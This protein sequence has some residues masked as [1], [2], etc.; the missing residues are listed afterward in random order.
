MEISGRIFDVML[1]RDIN[2]LRKSLRSHSVDQ[3]LAMI[4]AANR[5]VDKKHFRDYLDFLDKFLTEY[6][7]NEYGPSFVERVNMYVLKYIPPA[8]KDSLDINFLRKK[9]NVKPQVGE[10]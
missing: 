9:A 2:N 4:K 10:S 5:M 1:A 6:P 7:E 3:N 8:K